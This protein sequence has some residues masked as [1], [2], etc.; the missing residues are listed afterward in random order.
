ML[1]GIN[2]ARDGYA[3]AVARLVRLAAF[4]L[5][6]LAAVLVSSAWL[7]K[8]TPTGFLPAED[9]GAIFGEVQ[10]P[11]GASVN[12][13][14]SVAKRV[15]EIVR[16]TDGIAGLTTVVGYSM[17]DGQVKSNSAFLIMLL[18]P[19]DERKDA[20]LSVNALIRK[21]RGEFQAI[22]EANVI[23]YNLPPIIGLGTGSGFEYQ[24][25]SLSGSSA[26]D[27]AAVARGLVFAANQEPRLSNVFTTYA[28][29]TPQLYLDIDREKVRRRHRGLRRL[30]RPA[31]G[32]RQLLCQRL[33]SV[34][35]YLAGQRAGRG[36]R[37]QPHRHVLRINV[38]NARRHAGTCLRQ[39]GTRTTIAIRSTIC[40]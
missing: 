30:Q 8:V 39:R 34:R 2:Y 36:D 35:P 17:L 6:A 33:Q 38:R 22:R 20:A 19:F 31:S 21:L 27:V 14:A 40:A 11:E 24:L 16:S 13:T 32:A 23:A 1:A 26:A 37:S 4:G 15:E 25:Q 29:N 12:R 9:Q 5:V 3:T 7:F 28:A 18:K 10:L